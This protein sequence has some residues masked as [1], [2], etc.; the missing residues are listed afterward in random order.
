VTRQELCQRQRSFPQHFDKQRKGF[1]PW[2]TAENGKGPAQKHFRIVGN[3][4]IGE[5]ASHYRQQFFF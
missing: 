1:L 2:I 3:F 5:L 4:Y